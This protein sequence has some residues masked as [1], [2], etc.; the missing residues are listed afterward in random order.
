MCISFSAV[1]NCETLR[2]SVLRLTLCRAT[3]PQHI[4]KPWCSTV[5]RG[6]ISVYTMEHTALSNEVCDAI[7]D[8]SICERYDCYFDVDLFETTASSG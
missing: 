2:P 7:D 8:A 1:Y 3:V 6:I 5:A 4:V